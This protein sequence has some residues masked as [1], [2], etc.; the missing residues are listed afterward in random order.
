M[1]GRLPNKIRMSNRRDRLRKAEKL[2]RQGGLEAATG[3]YVVLI[4]EQPKDWAMRNALGDLYVRAKQIDDA[5]V[6][7]TRIA[8]HFWTE[9]FLP[10]AAALYKKALK[11]KATDEPSL[12]RVGEISAQQGKLV[13]AKAAYHAV[14]QAR[15]KRGD[16]KGAS[17]IVVKLGDRD[18]KDY[19]GRRA[20]ADALVDLGMPVD[21]LEKYQQLASELTEVG[22]TDDAITVLKNVVSIDPANAASRGMLAQVCLSAGNLD[23]ALEHLTAE[24]AI[25]HEDWE[26]AAGMLQEFV[27]RVPGHVGALAKLVEVSGGRITRR[28][29][30]GG[31]GRLGRRVSRGRPGVGGSVI[32]EDLVGREPTNAAHAARYRKALVALGEAN[33]DARLAE[34]VS[35]EG[36]GSVDDLDEFGTDVF[37]EAAP[38]VVEAPAMDAPALEIPGGAEGTAVTGQSGVGDVSLGGLDLTSV[39]ADE[40]G[41]DDATMSPQPAARMPVPGPS[42]EAPAPPV[43]GSTM[44]GN[45]SMQIDLTSVLGDLGAPAAPAPEQGSPAPVQG[46]L[47]MPAAVPTP[48]A[49]AAGVRAPAAQQCQLRLSYRQMGKLDEAIGSRENAARSPRYRFKAAVM[50]E[51][52]CFDKEDQTRAIEWLERTVEA[53]APSDEEH[54]AL[55]WPPRGDARATRRNCP[56]ACRAHGAPGRRW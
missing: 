24:V 50:L 17:E 43:S 56:C 5:V 19:V 13:D 49:P 32:A 20:A 26:A 21:A 31:P 2:L 36:S 23:A 37:G 10:K 4:E 27:Q 41:P 42:G 1:A 15:R 34:L 14:V 53:P 7:H 54:R 46:A 18:P 55:L 16:N 22:M 48:S 8:D 25:G 52:L 51:R 40:V 3:E 44:S 29:A 12:V 9:G 38:P 35:R 6:Q 33:P 47:P 45:R 28:P 30:C 11:V 39:L